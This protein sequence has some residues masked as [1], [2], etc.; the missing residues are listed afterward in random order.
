M[1]KF[2]IILCAVVLMAAAG[3][4]IVGGW[5]TYA[6][7]AY[8]DAQIILTQAFNPGAGSGG[9][10]FG[11]FP[12]G[13]TAYAYLFDATSDECMYGSFQLSH[14]YKEGTPLSCHIH[15]APLT[16][17][18]TSVNWQIDYSLTPLGGTVGA[19]AMLDISDAG[20]GTAHKHQTASF[21]PIACA[22][23]T[24]SSL[25]LVRLCR[26]ANGT[27]GTD[28]M[29]GDVAGLSFDCHYQTDSRGSRSESVK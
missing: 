15:W 19:S 16:T 5:Q 29:G 3:D 21:D 25:F 18:V 13:S 4:H 23:C 12:A 1:R 2:A 28:D 8:E 27:N 14:T 6:T 22:S 17:D 24:I 26:D 10:G 20:D 9:P 11:A 7:P